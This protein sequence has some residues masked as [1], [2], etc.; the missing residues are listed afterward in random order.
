MTI[1]NKLE[2]TQR[3]RKQ[4]LKKEISQNMRKVVNFHKASGMAISNR[5]LLIQNMRNN[6]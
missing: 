4:F 2:E 3:Q 5:K 1:K 6:S